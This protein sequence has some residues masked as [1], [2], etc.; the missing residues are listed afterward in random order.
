MPW[1]LGESKPKESK[2][3]SED[4]NGNSP[5]LESSTTTSKNDEKSVPWGPQ[6]KKNKIGGYR[7]D[8]FVFFKD[9]EDVWPSIKEFYNLNENFD[10]TCLL[11]RCMVGK[12]KN[13]YFCSPGVKNLVLKNECRIKIIN[14]G[15]K[16]FVRCDNKNMK[17][18][19]R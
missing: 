8:P 13:I 3:K 1:E 5:I 7:E 11:T 18:P 19:F 6:R 14:T 2:V 10:P 16:T 12:K 9:N 17:C 15:V 4:S